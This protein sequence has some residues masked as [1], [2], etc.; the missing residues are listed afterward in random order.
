MAGL[1]VELEGDRLTPAVISARG[2]EESVLF[3][4]L[5]YLEQRGIVLRSLDRFG[6][7]KHGR[8]VCRDKGYLVWLVGGYGDPLRRLDGFLTGITRYGTDHERDGRWVADGAAMLGR[9]DVVPH[10]MR[11]LESFDFGHVLD[12]GCGNA[13]FL[14]AACARFGADGTGVD[15]SPEACKEADKAVREAGFT[16]RVNIIQ[17]DAADLSSIPRLAHVQVVVTFFLLHEILAQGRDALVRYLLDMSARLPEKARL[18]V[19][20]VEPGSDGQ[21]FTPEF[22]LVH[23]LMRQTLLT[24]EDWQQAL[25]DGGFTTLELVRDD[26]PGGILLLAERASR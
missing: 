12:L 10:A 3:A 18:L 14:L 15:I 13:R 8:A 17:G 16:D 6:L 25:T 26:M 24:A 19:A 11:L 2:A 21:R 22:T 7:T 23:A 9:E 5:N 20:E 1:L 4:A